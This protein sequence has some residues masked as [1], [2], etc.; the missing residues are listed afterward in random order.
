MPAAMPLCSCPLS[1]SPSLSQQ[2]RSCGSGPCNRCTVT[3]DQQKQEGTGMSCL[4]PVPSGSFWLGVALLS[5]RCRQKSSRALT[6][7]K[8]SISPSLKGLCQR[9]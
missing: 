4:L 6:T 1:S 8:P 5:V 7:T 9:L 3:S 2:G